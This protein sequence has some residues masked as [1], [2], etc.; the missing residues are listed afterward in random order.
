MG[1]SFRFLRLP[2]PV[3]KKVLDRLEANG[4]ADYEQIEADLRDEGYRISSSGIHRY[5]QSLKSDREFL[6]RWADEYPQQA[7][8]L[9]AAIKASPAGGIKLSLPA[10]KTGGGK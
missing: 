10:P 2:K 9:V 6:R 1:Q 5:F 3:Q 8:A 4:G 7:A